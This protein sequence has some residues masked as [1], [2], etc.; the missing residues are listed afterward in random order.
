MLSNEDIKMMLEIISERNSLI[1][2]RADQYQSMSMHREV[3]RKVDK[4]EPLRTKLKELI[5]E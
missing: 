2:K 3:Q 1:Y 4:V 5:S